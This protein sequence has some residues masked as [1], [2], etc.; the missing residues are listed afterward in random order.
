MAPP[1]DKIFSQ[2]GHRTT[3]VI[4]Y[5]TVAQLECFLVHHPSY[6]Y[7]IYEHSLL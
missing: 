7:A 3:R 1:K 4:T 2:F 5:V 6:A